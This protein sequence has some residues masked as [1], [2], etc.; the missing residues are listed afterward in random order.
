[1]EKEMVQ[2]RERKKHGFKAIEVK[3]YTLKLHDIYF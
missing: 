2:R 3:Q 1:M